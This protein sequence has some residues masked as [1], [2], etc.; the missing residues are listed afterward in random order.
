MA[1]KNKLLAL[2]EQQRGEALSGTALAEQFGVS[3][4]AVWKAINALRDEG[5]EIESVGKSGY[6]LSPN[7]DLLSSEG[8]GALLSEDLCDVKIFTFDEVASTNDEAKRFCVADSSRAVFV[9]DCQTDG[10]GRYSRCFYSPAR[11]GLYLSAVIHPNMSI[12]DSSVYTAVAAVATARAIESQT[13]VSPK[14]KWVNDLYVD[15]KKICGILTE[16]MT[17]FETGQV[18]SMVIGIGINV[19]TESF[20]DEI[21]DK[22]ASIGVFTSRNELAASIITELYHLTNLSPN[23]FMEEYRSRCFIIGREIEF[24]DGKQSYRGRVVGI[25]DKCELLLD[26]SGEIRCFT[27]GEIT[28]F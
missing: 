28:G 3:R 10:R 11:T 9:S 7:S 12:E 27:H 14:I 23:D 17:D 6:R 26:V 8:I 21:S 5:H 22:A 13:N 20:P 18:R 15:G 19:T 25:G 1:L 24:S 16:A 4:N 2:L